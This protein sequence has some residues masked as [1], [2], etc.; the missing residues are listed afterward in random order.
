MI[1]IIIDL[2]ETKF[3]DSGR[4]PWTIVRRFDQF[5]CALITSHWKVLYMKLKFA[6]VCSS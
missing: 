5:L 2:P 4:K 3:S 6:S 1:I